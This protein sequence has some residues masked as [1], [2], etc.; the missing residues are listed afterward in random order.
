MC[1]CV[2]FDNT[3]FADCISF[4]NEFVSE[5]FQQ[6]GIRLSVSQNVE[7]W[8]AGARVVEDHPVRIYLHEAHLRFDS[9]LVEELIGLI[10]LRLSLAMSPAGTM[11]KYSF[12]SLGRFE[13]PRFV[14]LFFGDFNEVDAIGAVISFNQIVERAGG[15]AEHVLVVRYSNA[16]ILVVPFEIDE[17]SRTRAFGIFV[18]PPE[19]EAESIDGQEYDED[20][21][22]A[23]EEDLRPELK[24]RR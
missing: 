10:E 8:K 18:A 4:S 1:K 15:W 6:N 12:D 7:R 14:Q 17:T 19:Q 21:Q 11:Q 5:G 13:C 2:P 24:A 20:R 22:G 23:S 9:C 3:L 16:G